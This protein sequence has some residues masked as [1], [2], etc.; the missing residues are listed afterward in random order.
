M[1]GNPLCQFAGACP[2]P[3]VV[4]GRRAILAT[5]R[6]G[7]AGY[8]LK[9]IDPKILLNAIE[10]V[11]KGETILDPKLTETALNALTRTPSA[12]TQGPDAL[13]IEENRILALVVEGKT[14]KEIAREL[15]LSDKTVKNY[16]SNAF[17]KLGVNRRAHAATVYSSLRGRPAA[18]M[19]IMESELTQTGSGIRSTENNVSLSWI[20]HHELHQRVAQIILGRIEVRDDGLN[21][22]CPQSCMKRGDLPLASPSLCASSRQ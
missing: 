10:R 12:K 17:Q 7:A 2:V 5:I 14:N 22:Y 4:F 3:H 21:G 20:V 8:L 19:P 16:L 18:Y 11:A 1:P 9:E 6:A 15:G 13:S